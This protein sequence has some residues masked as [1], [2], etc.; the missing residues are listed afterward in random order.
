MWAGVLAV[1]LCSEPAR[2][3]EGPAEPSPR[4]EKEPYYDTDRFYLYFETGHSFILDEHFAGDTDF[5]RPNGY[6][7][8]LGGGGGYNL[9]DHWG[10]EI[11]G[12]GTEP[13]LRSGTYG[14]S[15]EFSNITV[16]AA[17]RYRRPLW[18]GRLVPYLTGG[19][20]FALNDINDSSKPHVKLRGDDATIA[21]TLAAGF[22]YFL[23]PSVAVG[24]SLHS[25][26]YP[27]IDT[28]MTVLNDAGGVVFSDESTMNLTSVALL[29]H[30]RVFPGQPASADGTRARRLF[31]AD[32]GPFDT[33]DRRY[34]LY[35]AAGDML[36]L[37]D[38]V[39]DRVALRAPGD[40]NWG[41]GCG[42]GVNLGGHWGVEL[43]L[44]S[45]DPNINF[46]VQGKF[47]EMG[48]FV[49]LPQ[50]RYRWQFRG[51]RL[52]PFATAGL[53]ATINDNNDHRTVV[54][55]YAK[56]ARYT[57]V[58][59]MEESSVVGSVGVGLEY[60][61]NHYLSFGIAVPFYIYPDWDTSVQ[62]RGKGGALLGSPVESSMNYSGFA[63]MARLTA[64][65]P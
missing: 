41:L 55:Q 24:A 28:S 52:V 4:D 11:Q 48:N 7:D 54:D 38:K 10:V 2:S 13:D 46:D 61:L 64:Y 43:Q 57:P 32:H 60:F 9:T 26:I 34:Y 31:I 16:A 36:F 45:T 49:I 14:K 33:D 59:D 65:I 25:W 53:G 58:V 6:N 22:D 40:L 21:G 63:P 51:G 42:L 50:L 56:G 47:A 1:L 27:D 18:G 39:G 8:V 62:Q 12:H 19:A 30:I 15:D 20:G 5:D 23:A 3:A 37:D 29:M 17:V 44:L 35:A